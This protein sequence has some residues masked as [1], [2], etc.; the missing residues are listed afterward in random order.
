MHFLCHTCTLAHTYTLTHTLTETSVPAGQQLL[1]RT[2]LH[3][4]LSTA[5]RV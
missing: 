1:K 5:C 2:G 4:V 3:S